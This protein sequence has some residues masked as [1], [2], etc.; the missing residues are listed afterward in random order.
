MS[1]TMHTL[2]FEKIREQLYKFTHT[3]P[4]S[5][6][7]KKMYPL[8][9]IDKITD[10][11][12]ET[13]EA[14]GLILQKNLDFKPC[15][16][17]MPLLVRAERGGVL[18]PLELKKIND[19]LKALQSLKKYFQKE[20]EMEDRYP[21]IFNLVL[22]IESFPHLIREL[23]KCLTLHGEIKDSASSRLSSLRSEEKTLQEKIRRLLESYLRKPQY[24]KYLQEN[25][26]TVRHERY[27]LPVKQEY[28]RYIPGVVHDQSASGATLFIEPFPVLE[29]NNQLRK[30]KSNIDKETEKILR[31]LTALIAD[32]YVGIISNYEVYGRLDFILARGHLSVLYEATEPFLNDKGIIVIA[33]GRHPL[34][35]PDEVVPVDVHLGKDF[36]TL[37]ITGPNT[38][39]K[40]VTLKTI[41][42]FVLMAQ[43][44]LHV[45]AKKGTDLGVFDNIW[46]DIGD[47]QDIEQSLSTFSGHMLN[48]IEIL[49]KA[50]NPA[51]VLLD[52]LGAGTDPSEGSA[53]AMAILEELHGRDVRTVATTHINELKVFAHLQEGM[54]NASMEFD[55]L[56]LK[57][58]FKLL[59]GVP[60]Q[61]NALNVVE[62]LGMPPELTERARS[63]MREDFLNLEEVV[64]G[65]EE[66]RRKFSID[67]KKIREIKRQLNYSLREITAEKEKLEQN[68]KELLKKAYDEAGKIVREAR[69]KTNEV[70]RMLN[71]AEQEKTAKDALEHGRKTRLALNKFQ[72]EIEVRG[73]EYQEERGGAPLN[74]EEARE[75][76]RVY[77]KNLRCSG[78]IA[79]ILSAE[80]IQVQ[81]GAIRINAGLEDLQKPEGNNKKQEKAPLKNKDKPYRD[82]LWEKNATSTSL[83][84]RG[85]TLDEAIFK[86]DKHMDDSILA[87]LNQ[88]E[89]I[90]GKGTGRLRQG[91][92]L[93]LKE[94]KQ[95][96]SFRLGAEGEGGSGVTIVNLKN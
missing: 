75:G 72:K 9:E 42:L 8:T 14:S 16:D 5:Q 61:S 76:Q 57:P 66:E 36:N 31:E 88:V 83:D 47:E 6:K 32:C 79:K 78:K 11:Q 26:V 2:E 33:E 25:L 89:I 51:L 77:I 70:L 19:F 50:A 86:V 60:G 20:D 40:T 63:Y 43:C 84:L 87:N 96:K 71:R 29:L 95:V 10:L 44:G 13:T 55:S 18:N 24:Q 4:G 48:I 34:L 30:T 59:I 53:L 17:L 28:R 94:K 49:S 74:L 41:G 7:V 21:R 38:G 92:H 56:T 3:V 58:S 69:R 73:D 85:L 68:K 15:D 52:E 80:E 23:D 82:L 35:P 37:V 1:K 22:G 54:E 93:Y 91:L 81:V 62:R 67:N 45:P 39:G 90:H 12:Q 64:S 65:L 46:A 27:V